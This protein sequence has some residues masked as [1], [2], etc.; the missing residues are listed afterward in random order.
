MEK[1]Y[2]KGPVCCKGT[3]I[4][5]DAATVVFLKLLNDRLAGPG[6][7]I[8]RELDAHNIFI[9]SNKVKYVQEQL[10]DRLL[11]TTFDDED[12]IEKP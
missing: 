3:L 2:D 6:R 7:F 9:H 4:T 10:A 11:D 8:I 5:T 1:S 12:L